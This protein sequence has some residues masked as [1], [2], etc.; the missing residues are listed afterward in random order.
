MSTRRVAQADRPAVPGVSRDLDQ[1]HRLAIA[2]LRGVKAE[3]VKAGI[4]PAQLSAL[5]VLTFG[6]PLSLGM[7][8]LAEGVSPP[9][10][11]RLVDGL[12]RRGLARRA[13]DPG[14]ARSRRIHATAR[15]RAL[16]LA[17]RAR[18]LRRLGRAAKALTAAER[19]ALAAAVPALAALVRTLHELPAPVIAPRRARRRFD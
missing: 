1:L 10:V 11:S 3:D 6:G 14:D 13:P 12:E 15:G 18:R 5:S 19:R 16:L 7:L 2:L 4:G 17:G 8:A 9:T